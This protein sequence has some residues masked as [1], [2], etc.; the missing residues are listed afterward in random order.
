MLLLSLCSVAVVIIMKSYVCVL[1]ISGS[2]YV[3][4]PFFIV[5]LVPV[6]C[7]TPHLCLAFGMVLFQ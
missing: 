4:I 1:M 7:R 3:K 6:S 2:D 5:T